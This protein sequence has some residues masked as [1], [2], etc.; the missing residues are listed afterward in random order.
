VTI[1]DHEIGRVKADPGQIE[2]VIVNL[3]LNARD[4]MPMGGRLT[5]ESWNT[6]LSESTTRRHGDILPGP[7]VKLVFQDNGVGM[8][9]ET[10]SHI[11][12]PY[13]TTKEVGK[14]VGLGLS[15]V[16]GIIRQSG[17]DIWVDSEPQ[18]GTTFTILLPRTEEKPSRES[19]ELV[20]D[21]PTGRGTI[22]VVEDEESVRNLVRETLENAGYRVFDAANGEEALEIMS[23]S[24]EPIH[25]LL[26]DVV[27]PKRGGRSLAVRVASLYPETK[28]LFMTGYVGPEA[29]GKYHPLGRKS[30]IFKPFT[31]DELAR[32]VRDVLDG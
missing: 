29:D 6:N 14:G 3:A 8:D 1:L 5:I 19:I 22:L 13:F 21:A 16:Y 11:F 26:T 12:E 30:S 28:I 9:E 15:T 31:P 2:Q 17:G 27:M 24:R 7:Y 20:L 4:A 10:K 18:K 25:L 32:K 23:R